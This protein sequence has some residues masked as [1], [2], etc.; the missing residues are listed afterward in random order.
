MKY[1]IE[2]MIVWLRCIDEQTRVSVDLNGD[3]MAV[4]NISM[5]ISPTY[6][7]GYPVT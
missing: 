4:A 5:A 1:P 7:I 6:E 2:W 3:S